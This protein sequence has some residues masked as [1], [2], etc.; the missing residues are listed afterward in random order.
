[1][2][3][4]WLV[5]CLALILF[6]NTF[7]NKDAA[8]IKSTGSEAL[9]SRIDKS[10]DINKIEE[11]IN[12]S[13]NK[14]IPE[15]KNGDYFQSVYD[16]K[17]KVKP[18]YL[19]KLIFNKSRF[20]SEEYL[21][22]IKERYQGKITTISDIVLLINQLNRRYLELGQHFVKAIFPK[23]DLRDGIIKIYFVEP[24]IGK[25]YLKGNNSTLKSFI[26]DRLNVSEGEFYN[27]SEIKDNLIKLN[28]TSD[29]RAR[30]AL[31]PGKRFAE[32]DLNLY[33]Y[34]PKKYSTLL[35]VDDSGSEETGDIRTTLIQ[36]F[37]SISGKRDDLSIN[38]VNSE[39]SLDALLSYDFF[40]GSRFEKMGLT[41]RRTETEIIEGQLTAFN[42]ESKLDGYT[43]FYKRPILTSQNLIKNLIINLENS[44]SR[45]FFS[46]TKVF[47]NKTT[48]I[49][50]KQDYIKYDSRGYI[51]YNHGFIS[52][53]KAAGGENTFSTYNA[54]Y[55]RSLRQKGHTLKLRASLQIADDTLIPATAQ[56]QLGGN[57]TVR[58][59]DDGLI[60][61][62]NG[63]SMTFE[64]IPNKRLIFK[65]NKIRET[66]FL[67]YGKIFAYKDKGLTDEN[68]TD[69]VSTGYLF[70][71]M[72]GKNAIR[73]QLSYPLKDHEYYS[74]SG[75]QTTFSLTRK[76]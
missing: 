7:S 69:I 14:R 53:V 45:T 11:K 54:F 73:V 57:A 51:Y 21:F 25:V 15:I 65:N 40:V 34:E 67:D 49:S 60:A 33:I 17:D 64:Y 18:F 38:I 61:G 76:F 42:I 2:S 74:E 16:I 56:F 66:L 50:I 27:I 13:R 6:I 32:T 5:L 58:G 55:E 70:D 39:G 72:F 75:V 31:K 19:K 3:K 71:A 24:V 4:K 48:K 35:M 1:M 63:Y 62:D 26:L 9:S 46:G 68:Y 41:I 8:T 43:L 59:Y 47:D 29:I 36:E 30:M 52:G 22:T 10:I 12:I 44:D 23:Q 37:K 28:F 20:F